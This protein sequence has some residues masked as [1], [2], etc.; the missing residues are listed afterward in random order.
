MRKVEPCPAVRQ[1]RGK[2]H[3]AWSMRMH[4]YMLAGMLLCPHILRFKQHVQD[5]PPA[6]PLLLQVPH[7]QGG[8]EGSFSYV[9]QELWSSCRTWAAYVDHLRTTY[10][11]FG[12][13]ELLIGTS[14][15]PIREGWGGGLAGFQMQ[16]QIPEHK[17]FN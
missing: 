1:D 12:A 5:S 2:S 9:V 7:G 14:M 6:M 10:W 3:M 17:P 15:G 16:Y 11:G 8:G 4:V 13:Q